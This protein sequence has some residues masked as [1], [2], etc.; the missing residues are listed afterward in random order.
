MPRRRAISRAFRRP[1]SNGNY[2]HVRLDPKDIA[3]NGVEAVSAKARGMRS[4]FSE[5]RRIMKFPG[6]AIF[7]VC[8]AP[9]VNSLLAPGMSVY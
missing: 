8:G 3:L 7:A 5:M 6:R 9:R 4:P 1:A 2:A